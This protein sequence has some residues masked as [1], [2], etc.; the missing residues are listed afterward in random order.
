M[1]VR[2]TD[3]LQKQMKG[4]CRH[5]G[6]NGVLVLNVLPRDLTIWVSEQKPKTSTEAAEM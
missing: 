1:A 4:H 3:C 6:Y 5:L 2:L